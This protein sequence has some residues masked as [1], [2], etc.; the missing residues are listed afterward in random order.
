MGNNHSQVEDEQVTRSTRKTTIAT[1]TSEAEHNKITTTITITINDL[2]VEEEE[3]QGEEEVE[4]IESYQQ[5][6]SYQ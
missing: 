4:V 5:R 6:H 1:M 3:D 2:I